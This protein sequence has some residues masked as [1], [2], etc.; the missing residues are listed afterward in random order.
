MRILEGGA[1]NAQHT[2]LNKET[3]RYLSIPASPRLPL[4]ALVVSNGLPRRQLSGREVLLVAV[5]VDHH[6]A[7]DTQIGRQMRAL[8][9]NADAHVELARLQLVRR[10]Q[11]IAVAQPDAR[12]D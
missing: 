10:G 6:I 11:I 7:P 5:G 1:I 9:H 2:F 12:A 4:S 3:R 8:A